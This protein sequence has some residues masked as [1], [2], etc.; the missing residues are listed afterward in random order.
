MN[1]DATGSILWSRAFGNPVVK[2]KLWQ[3]LAFCLAEVDTGIIDGPDGIVVNGPTPNWQWGEADAKAIHWALISTGK[4]CIETIDWDMFIQVEIGFVL[5]Y[6]TQ[7]N[8][9]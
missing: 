8:T 5:L 1:S 7:E 4:V 6:F 9:N 3:T 2:H